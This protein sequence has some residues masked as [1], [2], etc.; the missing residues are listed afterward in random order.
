MIKD[1][2]A[3]C[4]TNAMFDLFSKNKNLRSLKIDLFFNKS[5]LINL[6]LINL[7]LITILIFFVLGGS[8]QYLDI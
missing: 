6:T 5:I 4:Q 7:R 1:L 2:L 3:S 8:V